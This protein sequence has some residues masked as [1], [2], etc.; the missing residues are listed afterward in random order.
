MKKA[1]IFFLLGIGAGINMT[2]CTQKA[3]KS[4]ATRPTGVFSTLKYN[5][6]TG[7]IGGREINI[8]IG[9][10]GPMV[11]YQEAAGEPMTPHLVQA[12]ITDDHHISFR[13]PE[14]NRSILYTGRITPKALYLKSQGD[15]PQD[16]CVLPR[17]KGY[18]E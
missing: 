3:I 9:R 15:E 10:D 6:E 12:E 4:V 2:V 14:E 17:K 7:D 11:L 1:I 8:F 5:E 16:V 13:I 18:W